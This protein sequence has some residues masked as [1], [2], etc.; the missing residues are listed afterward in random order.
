MEIITIVDNLRFI[1]PRIWNQA[2]KA[3]KKAAQ[4]QGLTACRPQE[5]IDFFQIILSTAT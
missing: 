2:H 1:I 3:H 4:A 5:Y